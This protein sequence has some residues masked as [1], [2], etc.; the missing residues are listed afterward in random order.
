MKKRQRRRQTSRNKSRR[1]DFVRNLM[2][3]LVLSSLV[4]LL[5]W[6]YL[7]TAFLTAIVPVGR[8]TQGYLEDRVYGE[9]LF[10]GGSAL[11][12]APAPGVVEFLVEEGDSVRAGQPL[13]LV[14]NPGTAQTL[15]D[16]LA[17]ARENLASF[18]KETEPEFKFLMSA[19]QESYERAL[20]AFLGMRHAYAQGDLRQ[21]AIHESELSK[22]GNSVED[23]RLRLTAIE[24]RREELASMVSSIELAA[25]ESATQILAPVAGQF[26]RTLWDAD[27]RRLTDSLA[28]QDA[29]A[30]TVLIKEFREARRLPVKDG[31]QLAPGDLLG[32]VVSGQ[33]L[34]FYIPLKTEGGQGPTV[35]SVVEM[36]YRDGSKVNVTIEDVSHGRPPGFSVISGAISRVPSSKVIPVAEISLV[37]K[38][39]H[40]I[41]VPDS[42]ILE[43]DGQMGILVVRKTYAQFTPVEVLMTKD[44]KAVVQGLSE[45]DDIVLRGWRLLEGKRVR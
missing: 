15:Q 8:G 43:K 20:K 1:A 45:S 2:M 7:R 37:T 11:L 21:I 13:A 23:A 36:E 9:A 28:E 29:S 19:V 32:K 42:S 27:E 12:V 31:Q 26:S 39:K 6:P 5:T 14:R 34:S 41:L 44:R 25:Q 30:L 35:G 16:S 33:N 22:S 17:F 10:A 3:V 24:T 4:L 38:R 40:G 18:E